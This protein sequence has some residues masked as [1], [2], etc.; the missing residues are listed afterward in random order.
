MKRALFALINVALLREVR[1][2]S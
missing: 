2:S 1:A